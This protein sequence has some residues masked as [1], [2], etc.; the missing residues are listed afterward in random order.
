MIMNIGLRLARRLEHAIEITR[1]KI[2]LNL[3]HQDAGVKLNTLM[4]RKP[5]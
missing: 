1:G 2:V 4:N 5:V 3:K